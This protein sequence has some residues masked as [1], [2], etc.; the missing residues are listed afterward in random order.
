N[1]RLRAAVAEEARYLELLASATNI[2]DLLAIEREL[3]RIRTTIERY[4][5]QQQGLEDEVAFASLYVSM[6]KEITLPLEGTRFRPKQDAVEAFAKLALIARGI[7]TA[8]IHLLII[9]G[10]ISIPVAL[11]YL[12]SKPFFSTYGKKRKK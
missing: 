6:T 5:A 11:V 12:L 10:A 3:S 7:T 4:E 8:L 2:E 1:A 9:G